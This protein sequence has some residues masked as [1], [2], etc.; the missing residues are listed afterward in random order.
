MPISPVGLRPQKG[1]A[2]DAQQKQLQLRSYLK[3]K[4]AATVKKKQ[5]Y[6]CRGSAALTTRQPSMHKNLH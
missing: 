5:D 2:G 1:F 4:V 3:E 6:G